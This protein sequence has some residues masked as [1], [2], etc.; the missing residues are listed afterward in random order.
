M[1]SIDH[2]TDASGGPAHAAPVSCVAFRADGQRLASG[3]HD[4]SVIVWEVA[5]RG[6]PSVVTH[7]VQRAAITAVSW[8]P[9]AADLLAT[10]SADGTVAVW[11]VVDDR[12]PSLMK[13]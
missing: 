5:E 10:G 12:P 6:G 11:R 7:L 1:S 8:N 2:V 9:A 4:R 3:S 13:V